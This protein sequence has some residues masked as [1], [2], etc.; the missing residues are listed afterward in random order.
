[1]SPARRLLLIAVAAVV[2]VAAL[3]ALVVRLSTP[4]EVRRDAARQD[5]PGPV[6]LVPGYGGSTVALDVLAGQLR[7]AGRSATVVRL[8]EN[9]TGDL[10]DAAEALDT[11]VDAALAASTVGSVDLVGYSAGGVVARL[12]ASDRGDRVRRV[13]TLGAPHHG[14]S[15]AA[16]GAALSPEQCPVACQQLVPGSPLLEQLNAGDETPDGPQWLAV[17]TEQDRVVTPPD[18]ARLDGAVNVALQRLCPGVQVGHG[19]LP[20][21]PLVRALVLDAL[22]AAPL[23]PPQPADCPRLSS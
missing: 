7:A 2:A 10:R 13:V 22:S 23:A 17:W 18:S 11:A 16:L 12:W 9:G 4:D 6:L 5:L 21:A 1:V 20:T 8:P 14:T 3:G 19:D 15:V